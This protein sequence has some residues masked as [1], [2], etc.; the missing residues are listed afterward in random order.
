MAYRVS[1][2]LKEARAT[3]TLGFSQKVA[4]LIFAFSAKNYATF[5]VE[6]LPYCGQGSE[7]WANAY[8]DYQKAMIK[9][10]KGQV[11]IAI[12][13]NTYSQEE[14]G[15]LDHLLP[16]LHAVLNCGVMTGPPF[17]PL[18]HG[19]MP[20]LCPVYMEDI[21]DL[22]LTMEKP[23]TVVSIAICSTT[24]MYSLNIYRY[25][26]GLFQGYWIIKSKERESQVVKGRQIFILK[27]RPSIIPCNTFNINIQSLST[28]H[29][30]VLKLFQT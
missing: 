1:E 12:Q 25:P 23:L 10:I 20:L 22:L 6:Y 7:I 2:Q 4:T 28:G 8:G 27:Q 3:N 18:L 30:P 29:I 26:H 24:I 9:D 15:I 14:L 13:K 17:V 19:H 16:K 11:A 21:M 5:L